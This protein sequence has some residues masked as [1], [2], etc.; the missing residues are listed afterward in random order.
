MQQIRIRHP[1][2]YPLQGGTCYHPDRI[3]ALCAVRLEQG[4]TILTEYLI[5]TEKNQSGEKK[6]GY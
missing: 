4:L 1:G 6:T 2:S 5:I 3:M